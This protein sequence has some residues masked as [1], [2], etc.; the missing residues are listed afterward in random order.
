MAYFGMIFTCLAPKMFFFFFFYCPFPQVLFRLLE[1]FYKFLA[2]TVEI[3]MRK[4]THASSSKKLSKAK[5]NSKNGGRPAAKG[6]TALAPLLQT[7]AR[8]TAL[9]PQAKVSA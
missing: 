7:C 2:Q 5:H 3:S 8:N 1:T 4:H 6:N 9:L